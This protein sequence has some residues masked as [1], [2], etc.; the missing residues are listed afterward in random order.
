MA[1]QKGQGWNASGAGDQDERTRPAS[2]PKA[3]FFEIHVRG[4]LDS[5][6]SEWLEGLQMQRLD[7]GEMILSGN[8][9]DQA[10]LMGVL[11]KLN[12]LNLTILSVFEAAVK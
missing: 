8:L 6:W 11:N 10:A 12:R 3:K 7:S 4:H 5:G 2:H 9:E 1:D